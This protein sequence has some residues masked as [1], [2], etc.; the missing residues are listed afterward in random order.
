MLEIQ[1]LCAG[2]PGVGVLKSVNLRVGQGE[3]VAVLGPNGAGKTTL[4]KAIWGAVGAQF[5]AIAFGGGDLLAQPASARAHLGNA[6][7]PE[8]CQVFPSLSV[9]ENLEMG[10]YSDA[11]QRAWKEN[12][13]RIYPW[14]PPLPER[15]ATPAGALSGGQQQMLAIAR[16][17]A[18][19]SRPVMLDEPSLGLSPGLADEIFERIVEIHR[20]TGLTIPLVE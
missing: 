13:A 4:F 5:G 18:L 14:F 7:V 6:H 16:G 17:L 8:G 10:A 15:S 20:D 19:A 11:G 12:L 3:L 2:Y 9:L 1:G